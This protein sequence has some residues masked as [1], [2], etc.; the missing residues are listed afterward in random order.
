[1]KGKKLFTILVFL[2]LLSIAVFSFYKLFTI[3][4][5]VIIGN[6]N[7]SEREVKVGIGIKEGDFLFY[8][9]SKELYERLKKIAWIKEAAIRKELSGKLIIYIY[10]ST[11]VAVLELNER[12]YLVGEEGSVLEELTEKVKDSQ[13]ILPIIK[14]ID[15]FKNK[16]ALAESVRLLNF[17]KS[18]GL[19]KSEDEVLLTGEN[20]DTLTIKINGFPIIFGK[21]DYEAKLSKYLLI[22]AETQKRGIKLQYID[23]RFTDRVI[24]KPIE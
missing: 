13:I 12:K 16:D 6:K 15:P 20:P 2:I 3:R 22:L 21:G 19:I 9:S 1:M 11:P 24:V 14:N 4:Q 23:L 5:I 18:K 17:F 10:E 8:P 7:L